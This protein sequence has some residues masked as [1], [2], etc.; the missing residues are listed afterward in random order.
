M[1]AQFT[2]KTTNSKEAIYF[3]SLI[4]CS[5]NKLKSNMLFNAKN[6][7]FL[8]LR[9]KIFFALQNENH[10][11]IKALL[12]GRDVVNVKQWTKDWVR[13][14]VKTSSQAVNSKI[15]DK[16]KIQISWEE[17]LLRWN[18]KHFSLFLKDFQLPKIVSDFRVHLYFL[19]D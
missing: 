18:K 5:I 4:Y 10:Q 7:C 16:T 6:W 2:A 8:I 15:Q 14:T 13:D 9:G 1:V 12:K 17:K 11:N 3:L 19:V